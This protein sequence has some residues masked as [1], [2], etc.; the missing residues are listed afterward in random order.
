MAVM[1]LGA[2]TVVA[3]QARA[4]Q[5]APTN[6]KATLANLKEAAAKSAKEDP[7][8]AVLVALAKFNA[9]VDLADQYR[10]EV[11]KL[12][13]EAAAD[14][15]S[16]PQAAALEKM[17]AN[18]SAKASALRTK[19]CSYLP[20]K[21]HLKVEQIRSLE[22]LRGIDPSDDSAVR[23]DLDHAVGK[24]KDW[25][26]MVID[27]EHIYHYQPTYPLCRGQDPTLCRDQGEWDFRITY[28]HCVPVA[29][30]AQ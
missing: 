19:A 16:S 29:L 24:L 14:N 12:G 21:A 25:R 2:S 1:A 26:Y 4:D 5:W 11:E 22:V 15:H 10:I 8:K 18:L 30:P 6:I 23:A 3:V 20:F 13:Q 27:Q 28:A 7:A 9:A 17:A